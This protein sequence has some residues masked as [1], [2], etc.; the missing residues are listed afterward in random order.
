[1]VGIDVPWLAEMGKDRKWHLANAERYNQWLD[2]EFAVGARAL[3]IVVPLAE[4]TFHAAAFRYYQGCVLPLIAREMGEP[5]PE[6]AHALLVGM[7]LP[8]L[9]GVTKRGVIKFKR[10]STA[11][12]KLPCAVFCDYIDRLIAWAESPDVLNLR[13]PMADRAWKWKQQHA[14]LAKAS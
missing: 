7:F 13:I 10:R 6:D 9:L 3:L 8:V 2:G 12:L 5:N 14:R 11:M 4:D 1:M